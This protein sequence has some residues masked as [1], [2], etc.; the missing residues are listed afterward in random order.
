MG[1][2]NGRPRNAHMRPEIGRTLVLC[3]SRSAKKS[4]SCLKSFRKVHLD[5]KLFSAPGVKHGI[6]LS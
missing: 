5:R 1:K 6:R 4:T 2:L 3:Q